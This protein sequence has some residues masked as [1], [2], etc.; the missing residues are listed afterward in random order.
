VNKADLVELLAKQTSLSRN[1]SE[2]VLNATLDIIRQSVAKG[3]E[4]K[5]VGF[6]TFDRS[7]R[8]S[9]KGR[10]PRTGQ[11]VIIPPTTVPRFR[12]GKEFKSQVAT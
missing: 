12:P 11:E 4:V 7:A 6:G 10:N 2:D 9:R 5:L 8:K 3:H 1:Q